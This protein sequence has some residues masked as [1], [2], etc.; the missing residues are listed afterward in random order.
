MKKIFKAANES[1]AIKDFIA[2]DKELPQGWFFSAKEA[3]MAYNAG[4]GQEPA[5]TEPAESA[6]APARRG[7][8]PKV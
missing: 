8:K 3:I 7:R 2:D 1:V 4:N 5:K 6:P